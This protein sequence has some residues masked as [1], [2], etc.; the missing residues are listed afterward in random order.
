MAQI[1]QIPFDASKLHTS[2][3]MA[4]QHNM[5]DDGSGTVEVFGYLFVFV[6]IKPTYAGTPGNVT[7]ED[8]KLCHFTCYFYLLIKVVHDCILNQGI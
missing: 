5:V 2:P 1:K 7:S 3:Q 6:F 4:A 8:Y